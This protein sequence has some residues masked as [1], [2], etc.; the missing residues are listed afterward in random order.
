MFLAT[1][2]HTLIIILFIQTTTKVHKFFIY[3]KVYKNENSLQ[4]K[5]LDRCKLCSQFCKEKGNASLDKNEKKVI[6]LR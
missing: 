4:I 2:C 5:N 3:F 6:N 1:S